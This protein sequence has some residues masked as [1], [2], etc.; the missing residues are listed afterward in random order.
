MKLKHLLGAT[1]LAMSPISAGVALAESH[2]G[3]AP[4]EGCATSLVLMSWGGAY[5][6]SQLAA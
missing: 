5:Q 6:A 3:M 4:C 2:G 1:A